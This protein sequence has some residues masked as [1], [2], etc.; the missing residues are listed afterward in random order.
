MLRTGQTGAYSNLGVDINV[1]YW[2]SIKLPQKCLLSL[3]R[4]LV[5]KVK[6]QVVQ[7]KGKESAFKICSLLSFEKKWTNVSKVGFKTSTDII[8]ATNHSL[9]VL[10]VC[11]KTD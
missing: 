5:V 1:G 3:V 8:K 4:C 6:S 2:K 10:G 9:S 7:D 11:C